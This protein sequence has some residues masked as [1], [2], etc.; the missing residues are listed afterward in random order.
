[1]VF[2]AALLICA[3]LLSAAMVLLGVSAV[4]AGAAAAGAGSPSCGGCCPG[5]AGPWCGKWLA[6]FGISMAVILADAAFIPAVG[7]TIDVILTDGP[8][9]C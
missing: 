5:R 3:L 2:L 1:M 8:D 6:L 7:I 4:C 9:L